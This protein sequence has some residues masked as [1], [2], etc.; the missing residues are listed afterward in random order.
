MNVRDFRDREMTWRM[1]DDL[2]QNSLFEYPGQGGK[3]SQGEKGEPIEAGYADKFAG[4]DSLDA[5]R[6]IVYPMQGM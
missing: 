2:V 1:K 3:S 4:I 5:L 6:E